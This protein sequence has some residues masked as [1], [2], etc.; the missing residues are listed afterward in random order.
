MIYVTYDDN[1]LLTGCYRQN[2]QPSHTD[3][4]IE[5]TD[6]VAKNWTGYKANDTRN[7]VDVYFPPPPLP[8][9]ADYDAALTA[10]LDAVAQSRNW[11]DRVS[12]MARAGFAGPWQADAVAFGTWAD[13]CN[14][15]GYQLL[16]DYQAGTIP[17]PTIAEMLALLPEMVWPIQP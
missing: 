16:A 5:V 4:H 8:T 2:L 1:G 11:A 14:V 10:H 12:L 6:D 17:Q 13:G 15:I 3:C 7:G 9:L